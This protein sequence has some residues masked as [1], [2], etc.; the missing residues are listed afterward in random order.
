MLSLD[1]TQANTRS[2]CHLTRPSCGKTWMKWNDKQ[3]ILLLVAA[4]DSETLANDLTVLCL[5]T[6]RR[7]KRRHN[8]SSSFLRIHKFCYSKLRCL[9][10][11]F[12]SRA[13]PNR[14]QQVLS[15]AM[16]N[17][18]KLRLINEQQTTDTLRCSVFLARFNAL[19]RRDE[20]ERER[21]RGKT[22]GKK[23]DFSGGVAACNQGPDEWTEATCRPARQLA[24]PRWLDAHHAAFVHLLPVDTHM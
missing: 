19:E 22:D 16:A 12:S 14:P 13:I 20:E 7:T 1:E 24:T 5:A 4:S 2:F 17:I 21:A 23:R 6:K 3:S 15:L 11:H 9:L 8:T 18:F 10:Y